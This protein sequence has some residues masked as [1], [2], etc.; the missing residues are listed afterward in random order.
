[1]SD[2]VFPKASFGRLNMAEIDVLRCQNVRNWKDYVV[3]I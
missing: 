1:M 3:L 2:V